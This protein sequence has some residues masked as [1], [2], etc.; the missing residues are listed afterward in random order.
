MGTKDNYLH[1]IHAPFIVVV[2]LGCALMAS[3]PA[4]AGGEAGDH[5]HSED[6][7]PRFFGFV[8]DSTGKIVPD[9]RVTAEIKGLGSVVTRTDKLGTYKMP[10]FGKHIP[11]NDIAI[12]CSKDGYRQLRAVRR[13]PPSKTPVTAVETECVLQRVGAK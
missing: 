6:D 2:M 4:W 9:A 5:D 11:P 7:G 10:G 3:T 12:S 1:R 8:K 13:T